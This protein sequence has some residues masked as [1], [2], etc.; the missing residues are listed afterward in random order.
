MEKKEVMNYKMRYAAGIGAAIVIIYFLQ[1]LG[2]PLAILAFFAVTGIITTPEKHR[3]IVERF[4]EYHRTL[5]PGLGF[6]WF[7]GIV[8]TIESRVYIK[9]RIIPLWNDPKR[10]VV[11]D[12]IDGSAQPIGAEVFVEIH[13]PDTAYKSPNEEKKIPVSPEPE[14]LE[15]TGISGES[16][17]KSWLQKREEDKR[18]R[19]ELESR[20][21]V[22][23]SVYN[24]SDVD[25]AIKDQIQNAAR[26]YL[27]ELSVDEALKQAKGGYDLLDGISKKTKEKGDD[28][29]EKLRKSFLDYGITIKKVTID[30][31][32]LDPILVDARARLHKAEKEKVAAVYVAEKVAIQTTGTVLR[33]MAH[34]RGKTLEDIQADIEKDE[35]LKK[36]FLEKSTDLLIRDMERQTGSLLDIRVQGSDGLERSLLNIV[37]L[38]Q[39]LAGGKSIGGSTDKK[40]GKKSEKEKLEEAGDK[41]IAE[42]ANL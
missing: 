37:A 29:T 12:F 15:H 7:P 2:V 13:N 40:D 18:R 22:Y 3:T 21:G 14:D 32:A 19:Q 28:E 36:E 6:I 4:Q 26:S 8:E 41:L 11:I 30:D 33:A 31:F 42:Y 23:R 1:W 25:M 16:N 35:N 39:K 34:S 17:D 10:K 24:I 5:M 9:E 38:F 20:N 27:N